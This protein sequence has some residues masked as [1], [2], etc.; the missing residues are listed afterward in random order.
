MN[1][2]YT[3]ELIDVKVIPS[4]DTFTNIVK[5]IEWEITFFDTENEEDVTSKA[6]VL[7]LLD[8]DS[9]SDSSY[10]PW[11]SITQ[12][13]ILQFGLDTEGGLDFLDHLLENGHAGILADKKT[14]LAFV[15]KNVE[16]IPE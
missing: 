11:D 2:D 10:I 4:Q 7:S 9:L 1:I 13:Q 15:R 14:E 16:L 8:T 6:R 5:K 12:T 3:M